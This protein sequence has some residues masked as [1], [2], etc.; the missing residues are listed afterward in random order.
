MRLTLNDQTYL[1][2]LGFNAKDIAKIGYAMHLTKFWHGDK[3]ISK[4]KAVELVGREAFLSG[5]AESTL[6]ET[7]LREPLDQ[8]DINMV[9]FDS[10]ALWD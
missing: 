6:Y 7:A 3:K 2:S 10:S 8:A 5:I 9:L 1:L 4:K